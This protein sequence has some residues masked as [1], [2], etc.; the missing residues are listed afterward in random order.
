MYKFICTD[1]DFFFDNSRN[2]ITNQCCYSATEQESTQLPVYVYVYVWQG[3]WK[4]IYIGQAMPIFIHKI[5]S[6]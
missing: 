3:R 2:V 1:D 6:G 4:Q 5:N